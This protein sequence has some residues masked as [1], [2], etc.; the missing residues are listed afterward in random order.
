MSVVIGVDSSTQSCKVLAVDA[1]SGDVI[2]SGAAGHPD[3]TAVD[4]RIWTAA[5]REAW[6]AA[7][8]DRQGSVMAAGV[9]AQQHGMVALDNTDTPVHD[10]L[11]WNDTRSAADAARLKDDLGPEAW[12]DA[13]NLV[14]VASF[15]ISKL[16]WLAQ[17][18]GGGADRVSRVVLPLGRIHI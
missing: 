10:A 7:G 6:H 4:P 3:R 5:L 8:A 12:V 2:A 14:P 17:N 18:G 13:V 1:E 16:A 15:T 9:A 11:L